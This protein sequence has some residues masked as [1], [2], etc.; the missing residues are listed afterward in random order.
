MNYEKT[1]TSLISKSANDTLIQ[2]LYKILIT[3]IQYLGADIV[4]VLTQARGSSQI[5]RCL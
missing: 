5:T 3:H 4:I 2:E 1:H